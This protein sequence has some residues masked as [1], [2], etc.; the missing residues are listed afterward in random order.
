MYAPS[1]GV[2]D[3]APLDRRSYKAPW[4]FITNECMIRAIIRSLVV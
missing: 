1:I 3:D 2:D 4:I